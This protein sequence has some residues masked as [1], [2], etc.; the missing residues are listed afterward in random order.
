MKTGLRILAVLLLLSGSAAR[1]ESVWVQRDGYHTGILVDVLLLERDA[2]RLAGLA[3]DRDTDYLRF[4]WG[5]RRYYG[6]RDRHLGHAL[7][8]LLWPTRSVVEVS[9]FP[10]LEAAGGEYRRLDM[11]RDQARRLLGFIQATFDMDAKGRPV[12]E[13][14]EGSGFRYYRAELRYHLLH[15]CNNWTA[16]VLDRADHDVP[17]LF[18]ILAGPLMKRIGNGARG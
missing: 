2:P 18:S 7:G 10:S 3:R 11:N 1:A 4:G 9:G 12:L 8:A 14:I 5:D 15:N 16:K 6:A 13:R 17:W